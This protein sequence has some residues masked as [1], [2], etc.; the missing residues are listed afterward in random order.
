MLADDAVAG[1]EDGN[2]VGAV[3]GRDGAHGSGFADSRRQRLIVAGR[4]VG[5]VAQRRP[6]LPLEIRPRRIQRDGEPL[7]SAAE[8]FTEFLRRLRGMF[9]SARFGARLKQPLQI[10]AFPFHARRPRK[11]RQANAAGAGGNKHLPQR[12]GN[13]LAI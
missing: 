11:F 2:A 3:G 9:I 5:N 8:I 6:H 7:P 13:G 10:T 4:A 12:G 1:N